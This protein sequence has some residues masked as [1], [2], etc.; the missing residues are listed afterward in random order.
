MNNKELEVNLGGI[1]YLVEV[2]IDSDRI[3]KV[4][5]VSIFVEGNYHKLPM[6]AADRNTFLY[7][8]E[9]ALNECWE[10]YKENEDLYLRTKGE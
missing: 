8:Y 9:D 2:D 7:W 4:F 10:E 1:Q 3:Y 5:S 6:T